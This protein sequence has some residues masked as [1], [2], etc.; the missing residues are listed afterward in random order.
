MHIE[1]SYLTVGKCSLDDKFRH[2]LD[3]NDIGCH[4]DVIKQKVDLE[5]GMP[6]MPR[7]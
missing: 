3:V 1:A 7:R 6:G 5:R 2:R 4:R